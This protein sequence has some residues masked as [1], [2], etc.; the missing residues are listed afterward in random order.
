MEVTV[1]FLVIASVMAM[2]FF[3][4]Y[5]FRKTKVPDIL[6]LLLLGVMLGPVLGIFEREIFLNISPYLSALALL[7]ILFDGGLNLT[8]EKVLEE[9]HRGIS[10]AVIGFIFSAT[11]VG[12]ISHFTF[13]LGTATSFLLGSIVGG[14]SSAIVIPVV[15]ELDEFGKGPR[16]TLD[17]ESVITDPL[18]IIVALIVMNMMAG[19]VSGTSIFT[20]DGL[21]EVVSTFSVSVIVGII[22]GIF[23]LLV[24]RYMRRENYSYMLT[25]SFL[26][27]VYAGTHTLGGHGAVAAFVVGLILGNPRSIEDMFGF[28]KEY[29]G[30]EK[31]SKDMQSYISLFVKTFFFV[32]LGIIITFDKPILF[33]YGGI[34]TAAILVVRY[35]AVR[36]VSVGSEF[37]ITEKG[38]MTFMSPRGLAA[39][40]LASAPAIEY[41]IPGTE[42]FPE[43]VFSVILGTSLVTTLGVLYVEKEIKAT[44][45]VLEEDLIDE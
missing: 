32:I 20:L 15:S 1:L 41:G 6:F 26:F 19:G 21:A 45:E 14:V 25:L 9:V 10:L 4:K 7:M 3:G 11:V 24:L 43:I 2:G 37:S 40:V 13:G 30:L 38:I 16:L 42:I 17:I 33:L 12:L 39:A 23:W 27:F 28:E 31:R 44:T 18:C 36:I 22:A 8:M 35:I 5:V 34:L 29:T